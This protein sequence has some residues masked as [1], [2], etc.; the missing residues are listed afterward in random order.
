MTWKLPSSVAANV[1]ARVDRER[2][3]VRLMRERGL[4]RHVAGD[5]ADYG[6][7][8]MVAAVEGATDDEILELNRV[9]R[10]RRDADD[11]ATER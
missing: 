3:C 7:A 9:A 8:G 11:A 1:L 10:E 4:D 2:R 5:L 6:T